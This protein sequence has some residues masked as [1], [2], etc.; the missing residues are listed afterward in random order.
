M[1]GERPSGPGAL[2]GGVSCDGGVDLSVGERSC[3]V[4]EGL[5]LCMAVPS[6]GPWGGVIKR[7]CNV[8][9]HWG[10]EVGREIGPASGG[11]AGPLWCCIEEVWSVLIL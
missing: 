10:G 1:L 2:L 11:W 3:P 7:A 4:L 5:T 8:G 6:V 9:F